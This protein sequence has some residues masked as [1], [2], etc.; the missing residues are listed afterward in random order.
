M[1]TLS[2]FVEPTQTKLPTHPRL[3]S[4]GKSNDRGKGIIERNTIRDNALCGVE[5]TGRSNA[6]LRKNT[7]THNDDVGIWVNDSSR[8]I[9]EDNNLR[10]NKAGTLTI[11]RSSRKGV[12]L[13]RNLNDSRDG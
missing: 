4:D 8:A 12:I 11:D 6:T 3:S 7:I 10:R 5:I 1:L 2:L 9:I 13:A